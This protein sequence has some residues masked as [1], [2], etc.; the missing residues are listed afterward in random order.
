MRRA[1]AGDRGEE[2]MQIR[3]WWEAK[4]WANLAVPLN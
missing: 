2:V 1:S 4:P 3:Q